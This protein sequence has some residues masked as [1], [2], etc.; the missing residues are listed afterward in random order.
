MAGRAAV[1]GLLAALGALAL[2]LSD[3]RPLVDRGLSGVVYSDTGPAAGATVRLKGTPTAVRS[4]AH[5]R[6]RL[7]PAA[8]GRRVTAWQ[9]GFLIAGGRAAAAP[10]ALRLAPLPRED[11]EEYEWV[12]PVPDR[13]DEGRCGNCHRDIY[14]EWAAGGHAR[15]AS[16][17]A[18][19]DLYDDLLREKPT[20]ADVCASCHAP[21]ASQGDLRQ[22]QGVAALGTH[23]DYCHKVAGLGAGEIGLTHGR[24]LHQLLRPAPGH[25]LFFGPLD[26][27]DRGEDAY[28]PFYRDSRYCAAC[29]EGVVFGVHVYATYS[30]WRDSPAARAGQHCQHCH[31]KPTGR[32]TN[33][34]PGRGGIARDSATLA[35]HTFWDGSQLEML[36][37]SL[38]L[39]ARAAR[40]GGAV[41]VVMKL[42]AEG[43]GHRVP[44]GHPDRQV[45]LVVEAADARG[46]PEAASEG[47][48]LP[49]EAGA[50]AGLAGKVYARQLRDE[51]GHGPASFWR[52]AAEAEDTRLRPGVADAVAVSFPASASRLRV[53]VLHRRF[54]AAMREAKGWPAGDLVVIDRALAVE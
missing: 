11:H 22:V 54:W 52:A 37:R 13:A 7:P 36:R 23:C 6:F 19:R 4:D 2:A 48:R 34:A 38:R 28:S 44:T 25:Q 49:P 1:L 20:G 17:R 21:T 43:V 30:E 18:F 24:F 33:V 9:D 14:R 8:R 16:G 31:M 29:H 12:S 40:G 45:I 15:S 10:L 5:G 51:A 46:R 27:V 50:L 32:M 39:E 53:R 41:R 47:P 35:N 42:T 3:R 26:D